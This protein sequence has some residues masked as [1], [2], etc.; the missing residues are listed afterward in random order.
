MIIEIWKDKEKQSYNK[1]MKWHNSYG[2]DETECDRY[3]SYYIN[4]KC[5]NIHGPAIIHSDGDIEYYLDDVYYT[6]E[7]WEKRRHDY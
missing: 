4:G 5:H 7:E 6:K 2:P 1:N 3:K